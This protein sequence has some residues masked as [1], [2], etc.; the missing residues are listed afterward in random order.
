MCAFVC[1]R[2]TVEI[3][4]WAASALQYQHSLQRSDSFVFYEMP[5]THNSCIT[6]ADGYGIEKYF[7][8]ALGKLSFSLFTSTVYHLFQ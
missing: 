3:D 1:E 6:E 2:G 5:S 8:S 4:E 7:I